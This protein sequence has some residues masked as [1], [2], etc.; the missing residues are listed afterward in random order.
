MATGGGPCRLGQYGRA[1]EKLIYKKRIPNTAVLTITDENGYNGMGADLLL[2]A[3]QGIVLADVLGDIKSMITV[4]AKDPDYAMKVFESSWKKC[5]AYFEGKLSI[6]FTSLLQLVSMHL[7]TIPLKGDPRDVPVISLVGEIFV[8]RDEFSRKNIVDYFE[9]RGFR[10]RI[11]PLAEYIC[12]SNYVVNNGLGERK[13]TFHDQIKM[14]LTAS[15]QE[16]W[17]RRIKSILSAS[18]LYRFEMIEVDKTIG[19]I[20]HLLDEN[21]RGE[22]ILTV[23]LGMREI[24]EDSCGVVAIGPFG[25]MYSRMAEAMLNK[26]MDVTGKKRMPGWESRVSGYRDIGTLPFLSIETDGN[27]FPQL[28]EANLE[29]FVLQAHRVHQKIALSHGRK[30]IPQQETVTDIISKK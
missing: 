15:V 8:R 26:E 19:G 13:F 28:I 7:G 3:W 5:L 2:R 20:K 27:P 30:Y 23:G 1:L 29:S 25:C 24:L 6:R 16:W 4:A 10:V 22:C 9:K 18:G 17:E 21:F 11:A 12:Y 14:R